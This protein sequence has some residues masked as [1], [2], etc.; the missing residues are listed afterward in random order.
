[1]LNIDIIYKYEYGSSHSNKGVLIDFYLSPHGITH[2]HVITEHGTIE[3]INMGNIKV[4]D[5]NFLPQY[6]HENTIE[7]L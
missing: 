4:V 3:E 2:A 1:M 7:D 5:R 6:R